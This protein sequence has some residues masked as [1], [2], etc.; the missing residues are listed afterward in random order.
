MVISVEEP[1]AKTTRE[2]LCYFSRA[3]IVFVAQE[4]ELFNQLTPHLG[5]AT[6]TWQKGCN[7]IK[8]WHPISV[9][10]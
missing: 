9:F 6:A 10:T 5:T 1:P 7:N 8:V 3:D 2:V 4:E